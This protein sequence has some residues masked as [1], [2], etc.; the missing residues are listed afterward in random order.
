MCVLHEYDY[1]W[2]VEKV[3]LLVGREY[4]KQMN[5]LLSFHISDENIWLEAAKESEH[6]L[7]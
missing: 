4:C 7:G 3:Q 2:P 1:L 6:R 5:C